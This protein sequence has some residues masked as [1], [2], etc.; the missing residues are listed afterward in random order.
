[1]GLCFQG[2]VFAQEKVSLED[3]LIS[4][5]FKTLAKTFVTAVDI[6]KLKKDNIAK[7][8]KM[9][10]EKFQKRYLKVYEVIKDLPFSLKVRYGVTRQMNKERAIK[11]VEALDKKKMYEII[12]AVPDR[13]I[14]NQFRQYLSEKKQKIEKSNLLEQINKLWYKMTEKAEKKGKK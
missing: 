13:V 10:K 4:S 7:L 3:R 5:T 12:D 9:D 11:I 1:M 2:S 6:K 14:A 8:N